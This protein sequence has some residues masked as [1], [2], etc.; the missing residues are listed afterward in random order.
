MIKE[1]NGKIHQSRISNNTIFVWV[2]VKME[3]LFNHASCQHLIHMVWIIPIIDVMAVH[4]HHQV[5]TI[6]LVF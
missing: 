3:K 6:L 4:S 1:L 2:L 5:F